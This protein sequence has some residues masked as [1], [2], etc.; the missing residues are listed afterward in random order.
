MVRGGGGGRGIE[1][2]GATRWGCVARWVRMRVVVGRVGWVVRRVW[3]RR[4]VWDERDW[5][6]ERWV[7][8]GGVG[9]RWEVQFVRRVV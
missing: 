4:V 9:V 1:R 5:R 3:E 6:V 8:G 2:G 7:V